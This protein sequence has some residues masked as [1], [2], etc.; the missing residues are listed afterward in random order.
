MSDP[1]SADCLLLGDIVGSR[2][3]PDRRQVH[4]ALT[5]ALAAVERALPSRRG[6]AVT[7]GDEFQGAYAALG[8]ALEVALRVR[9]LLLPD[10]DVRLGIGRGGASVLDAGRGVEDGPGWWAAREALEAVEERAGHAATRLLRT[11]HRDPAAAP[12]HVEAV[13]AALLCRDHL[14][15][16][17]SDRSLR[18]LRGLMDPDTTQAELAA[19]EGVSASAVS[20]RVR[21]DG[22]GAVLAAQALLREL[23]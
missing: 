13:N 12:G 22:I 21:A 3:A 14:V 18:L 15:G 2:S 20:Q 23:P 1:E 11:A 4:A 16:S 17:L 19:R 5:E 7:V 6:L 9:L 8:D 10:V